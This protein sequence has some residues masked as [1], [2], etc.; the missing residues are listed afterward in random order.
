MKLSAPK[1]IVT[2][3][4]DWV[5]GALLAVSALPAG[6][7]VAASELPAGVGC[8]DTAS[9]PHALSTSAAISARNKMERLRMEVSLL[10]IAV[11][12][13]RSIAA[14]AEELPSQN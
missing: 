11:F 7:L 9:K 12:L 8:S 6:A 1:V 10:F 4:S 14:V 13:S 2:L 3:A 5:V